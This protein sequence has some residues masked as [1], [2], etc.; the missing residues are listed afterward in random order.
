MSYEPKDYETARRSLTR[1]LLPGIIIL[2][3]IVIC[4]LL[5]IFRPPAH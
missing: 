4:V 1:K 3:I 5:M 2:I